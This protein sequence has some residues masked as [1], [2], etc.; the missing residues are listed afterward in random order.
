MFAFEE[1]EFH[2]I[3]GKEHSALNSD[4]FF[5][6]FDNNVGPTELLYVC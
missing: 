5:N 6:I 1:V 3:K 2:K 4:I